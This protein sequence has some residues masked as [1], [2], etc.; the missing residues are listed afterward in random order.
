MRRQ[1][2]AAKAAVAAGGRDH[3]AENLRLVGSLAGDDEAFG[4]VAVAT[5]DAIGDNRCIGNQRRAFGRLPAAG[6]AAAMMQR[7][8]IKGVARIEPHRA[9]RCR[10]RVKQF[11]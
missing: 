4:V 9:R 3:D 11:A 1:K 6:E 2:R 5:E 10:I 7:R 8:D